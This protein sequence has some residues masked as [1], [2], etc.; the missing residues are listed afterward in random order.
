M[1]EGKLLKAWGAGCAW[2]LAVTLIVLLVLFG[3]LGCLAAVLSILPVSD[4]MRFILGAGGFA[5]LFFAM[6][7]GAAAWAIWAIRKRASQFDAAFLPLGLSGRGY[8]T[9]GRQYHGL[10]N[11]R[12]VDVYFYRGPVLEIYV[13]GTL[14][15]R[16]GISLKSSMSRVAASIIK[17][18]PLDTGDPALSELAIYPTDPEWAAELVQDPRLKQLLPRLMADQGPF[19]L[20]NLLIQPEA[21]QLS[22]HHLHVRQITPEA[23][24]RWFNDLLELVQ[25]AESLPPPQNIEASSDLERRSRL[26]RGSYILPMVLI[27]LGVLAFMI[28]CGLVAAAAIVLLSGASL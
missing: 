1:A 20:R 9:N 19:E 12:Q 22:M 8:L 16:V 2:Q 15:T 13:S 27:T 23:V 14:R 21:V 4:D 28:I 11:G 24:G 3:G 26:N 25:I 10:V 17:S 5:L 7:G 6:L 18:A